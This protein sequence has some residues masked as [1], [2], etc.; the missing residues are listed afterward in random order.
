MPRA[1]RR[2]EG[3]RSLLRI[4]WA[5]E[6]DR[7]FIPR[8]I[9]RQGFL[10][11]RRRWIN[12]V[13][14]DYVR[15]C[16]VAVANA[17]GGWQTGQTIMPCAAIVPSPGPRALAILPK[18]TKFCAF[19]A[20]E[21]FPML[22]GRRKAVCRC[23]SKGGQWVAEVAEDHALHRSGILYL[24]STFHQY[25]AWVLRKAKTTELCMS[26]DGRLVGLWYRLVFRQRRSVY[27]IE[28]QAG[29]FVRPSV[30]RRPHLQSNSLSLRLGCCP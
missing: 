1:S 23:R 12:R 27:G 25:M 17:G 28:E 9:R 5:G 14:S 18:M 13:P 3:R 16:A 26:H 24:T 21:D 2:S 11:S 22:L 7:S 4:P 29:T 20:A 15:L 19:V 8:P 6:I 10:P 30:T